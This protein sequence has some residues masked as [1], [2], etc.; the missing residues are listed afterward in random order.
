M[1]R[2]MTKNEKKVGSI[3]IAAPE[4][5]EALKEIKLVWQGLD[6]DISFPHLQEVIDK[7]LAKA[8]GK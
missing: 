8:E 6:E 5:Y 7:A 1:A 3:L 4:M 2:R